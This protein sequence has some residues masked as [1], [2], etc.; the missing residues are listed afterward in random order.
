M[1][2]CFNFNGYRIPNVVLKYNSLYRGG[3]KSVP[4]TAELRESDFSEEETD[5]SKESEE[6]E[7]NISSDDIE[8]VDTKKETEKEAKDDTP[9]QEND[10]TADP[11]KAED[12]SQNPDT[13]EEDG[14]DSPAEQDSLEEN[15]ITAASEEEPAESVQLVQNIAEALGI[16]G[17]EI[18]YDGYDITDGYVES[19]QYFAVNA[20]SGN[21][22]VVLNFTLK[23]NTDTEQECNIPGSNA[24]F[25]IVLNGTTKATPQVTLLQKDFARW[26]ISLSPGEEEKVVL[27]TEVSNERAE[28]LSSVELEITVGDQTFQTGK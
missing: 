22:L 24:K 5:S 2:C 26:N 1:F 25:K 17:V 6:S 4:K 28:G 7:E 3:L 9:K 8:S 14:A 13:S 27:I 11:T 15:E 10:I 21:Q 23:N 19:N 12:I 16:S 20:M 18:Q